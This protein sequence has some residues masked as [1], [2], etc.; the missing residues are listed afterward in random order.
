MSQAADRRLVTTAEICDEFDA[1]PSRISE[2]YGARAETGFPEVAKTEGRKR[3]WHF[4][5]VAAFF[6]KRAQ[7]RAP[8]PLPADALEK[9]QGQLLTTAEVA[10]L[11]GYAP[12]T[13]Y[14]WLRQLPGYFPEPDETI[15]G[16]KWRLSTIVAWHSSR[17]GS[18]RTKGSSRKAEALPAVSWEGDPEDLLGTK[19]V[20]ALLGFSSTTS[21]SSS[22]YQGNLPQLQE[23]VIKAPGR[24]GREVNK[25][26]R[27]VVAEVARE[28]GILKT[29]TEE[30]V[31]IKE[32]A[33]LLGYSDSNSFL[34]A[35]SRG[36]LP[37]LAEPDER[38]APAAGGR[39]QPRW[40]RARVERVAAARTSS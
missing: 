10:K 19:E 4:D 18:G 12:S 25:W 14:W 21:F 33:E 1:R 24:G 3:Y 30:T 29:T 7:A 38:V 17:P 35:L 28:R 15:D 16:M 26:P 39:Q 2:W 32:T 37:E 36:R 9:D 40:T 5:D 22:L 13:I 23:N 20:A 27:R 11:L 6:A 31:G 8:Q 34:S